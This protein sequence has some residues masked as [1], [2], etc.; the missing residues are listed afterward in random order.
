MATDSPSVSLSRLS[1]RRKSRQPCQ[2]N[3]GLRRGWGRLEGGC[4]ASERAEAMGKQAQGA[5]CAC[6][7][8]LRVHALRPDGNR[9]ARGA[10]DSASFAPRAIPG[11]LQRGALLGDCSGARHRIPRDG[12]RCARGRIRAQN[13]GSGRADAP[14]AGRRRE[15]R[16]RAAEESIRQ[17]GRAASTRGPTERAGPLRATLSAPPPGHVAPGGGKGLRGAEGG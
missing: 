12:T 8:K 17:N 1:I 2:K 9:F 7:F 3:K 6:P 4:R 14:E 5:L 10:R 11:L 15:A 13:S 16:L